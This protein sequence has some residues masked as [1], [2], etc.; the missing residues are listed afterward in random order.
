MELKT[1][2]LG[3]Q[4]QIS[5]S[6]SER[7]GGSHVCTVGLA[8]W[9]LKFSYRKFPPRKL[10]SP[11]LAGGGVEVHCWDRPA[12]PTKPEGR[13]PR[14]VSAELHKFSAIS[15]VNQKSMP[16]KG[17]DTKT[18][19]DDEIFIQEIIDLDYELD[20]ESKVVLKMRVIERSIT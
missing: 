6:V 1:A 10:L 20:V 4:R 12:R 13:G 16:I 17:H 3:A 5:D 7:K 18:P 19:K 2:W 9:P 8:R 11:Q 15:T 14:F